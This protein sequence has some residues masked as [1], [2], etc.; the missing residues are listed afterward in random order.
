MSRHTGSEKNPGN[1]RAAQE[2]S[3]EYSG[4]I[5]FCPG[6]FQTAKKFLPL[7]KWS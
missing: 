2:Y 4:G 5:I 1:A 6:K 7:K 3:R